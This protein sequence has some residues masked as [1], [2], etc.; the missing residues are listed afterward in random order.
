[1]ELTFNNFD[2]AYGSKMGLKKLA[3]RASKKK[4]IISVSFVTAGAIKKLNS[5]YRRKNKATDVLSFNMDEKDL[6]GD[7]FI[8]PAVARKNAKEYGV[9][10]EQEIARL[11]VHGVLHLMGY[12]H[13]KKMFAKQEKILK[14]VGHA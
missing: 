11:F 3:D 7:I 12:D 8:C 1:M 13:G 4:S 2:K 10:L 5:R 9:T 6:L 14:E